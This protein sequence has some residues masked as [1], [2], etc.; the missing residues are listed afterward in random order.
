MN[1]YEKAIEYYDKSI[2]KNNNYSYSYLNKSAIYIEWEEYEN[3]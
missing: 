2:E 1:K 3:L